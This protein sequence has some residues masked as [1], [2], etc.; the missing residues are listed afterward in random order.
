MF[1]IVFPKIDLFTKDNLEKNG[2]LRQATGDNVVH[3]F[4]M[5]N[6]VGY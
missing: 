5:L 4:C 3:A 1:S 2:R 6:K